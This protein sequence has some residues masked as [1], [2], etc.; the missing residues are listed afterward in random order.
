MDNKRN[1]AEFRVSRLEHIITHILP[2]FDSHSLITQKQAD[3]ILFKEI[4]LL[5]SRKLHLSEDG[6]Q[7]IV[8]IR[9]ALNTGLSTYLVSAFP[10]TQPVSRPLVK[11][12]IPDP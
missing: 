6:L 2:H 5:K 10:N 3:Y 9:A 8:N 4:V 11:S 12:K 7:N 1:K